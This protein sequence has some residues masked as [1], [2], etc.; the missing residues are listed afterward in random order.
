MLLVFALLFCISPGAAASDPKPGFS[1][2]T[3]SLIGL[4]NG[5]DGEGHHPKNPD[6][7]DVV[8]ADVETTA[9]FLDLLPPDITIEGP[10]PSAL[11]E[12]EQHAFT[13]DIVG[14]LKAMECATLVAAEKNQSE[15]MG[16]LLSVRMPARPRAPLDYRVVHV[17]GDPR[18]KQGHDEPHVL[19]S[20]HTNREHGASL[21]Q[22]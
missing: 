2:G 4:L 7:A 20:V 3:D 11:L 19:Q 1:D 10:A 12:R 18:C 13:V 22:G 21:R 16:L 5:L 6:P 17:A 8:S 15:H 14:G 9:E